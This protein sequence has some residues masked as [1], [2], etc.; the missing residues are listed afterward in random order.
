[1]LTSDQIDRIVRDH[2]EQMM[3]FGYLPLG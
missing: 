1:V 3:R 2:G